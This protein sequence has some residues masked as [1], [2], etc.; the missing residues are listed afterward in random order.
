MCALRGPTSATAPSTI[1]RQLP[2]AMPSVRTS[3]V[4]SI[5]RWPPMLA[6]RICGR[7]ARIAQQSE[8]VP[9]TSMKIPSLTFSY[10]SAPAMPAAGPESIVRI[11]RRSISRTSITPPSLR[12]IISGAAMAARSTAAAVMCEVRIIRGKNRR[13]ERRGSRARAQAVGRANVV[14]AGR[15]GAAFARVL[16]GRALGAGAVDAE[17][18]ARRDRL[19]P[20]REQVRRRPRGSPSRRSLR[21]NANAGA[22]CQS[23]RERDR[24]ERI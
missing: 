19:D 7:P 15:V 17:R 8:L 23:R 11:G 16:R 22:K 21:A 3:S 13:V 24:R 2:P 10:S 20:A 4:R 14:P 9:P 12:M 1:L 6:G 18:L 5:V